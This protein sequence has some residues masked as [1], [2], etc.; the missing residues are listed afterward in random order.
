MQQET[1]ENSAVATPQS[2]TTF[3]QDEWIDFPA[4]WA[5]L[6]K[7]RRIIGITGLVCL[8]VAGVIA[9]TVP[10]SYTSS[11]SFITPHSS[12]NG[13]SAVSAQL[14][15]IGV[16]SLA[17]S[18]RTTGDMYAGI[19]QSRGVADD[20]ISRFNLMKI[21]KDNRLSDAEK[22]LSEHTEINTGT[23]ND[24]MSISVTDHDAARAR[25]MANAYLDELHAANGRL[26]LTEASQRR[27]FFEQQMEQEKNALVQTMATTQAQIAGR[28]VE[29]A[30]LLQGST[31][32]DP[33][34][35]RLRSEI[36]DLKGQLERM[37]SGKQGDL[38]S[39]PASKVPA[40]QLEYVRKQ[41][42]VSYHETL[43]DILAKQ[44]E[45]AK[46][47]ESHDAPML[48][49]V[50]SANLPDV[51]SSPHRKIIMLIGMLIGMIGASIWVLVRA[52]KTSKR[53]NAAATN[54]A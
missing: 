18:L 46:L 35:I 49:V 31:E 2:V 19:L 54:R 23:K 39:I 33:A 13:L 6:H 25:D 36:Q 38:S 7:G 51:K 3:V 34:V 32:Q 40:I 45:A 53:S 24:I 22:E 30:G 20:I 44:Y 15:M 21:Y 17:S 37:Q 5:C 27:L 50:D 12:S 43:F 14:S 52:R 48:Q 26:A 11:A 16:G 28:Q 41:R 47:D 8:L 42:E 10:N 29:L 1:H 9:Y 4:V